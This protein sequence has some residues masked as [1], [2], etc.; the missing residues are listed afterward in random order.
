[1]AR[2]LITGGSTGI[3]KALVMRLL[4]H[5][6]QVVA[7]SRQPIS[8][9]KQA[10]LDWAT[11][12]LQEQSSIDAFIKSKLWDRSFDGIVNNAGFGL[13][14]PIESAYLQEI[15]EQ[16]EA[17]YFGTIQVTQKAM[18]HFREQGF[19][20]VMVNTSIGGRIAFPYFG[21]YNA[22]KHAL[23][24]TFESLWYEC[25]KSNI[26]IKIIEPGFTQTQF[27]THGMRR[28][29]ANALPLHSKQIE[30]LSETMKSGTT[31]SNPD[32]IAKVMETALFDQTDR[33]RYT[34]G[35]HANILLTLRRLLPEA[36]FRALITK[37]V[38]LRR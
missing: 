34:A 29:V 4:S 5:G 18:D 9:M 28:S 36:W 13:I 7:T 1:M 10:G 27:A 2:I 35:K 32:T 3:G 20:T 30:W 6:H 12:D 17:N 31:G 25:L 15:R 22:T 19:G 16:F 8:Q 21:Y 26:R 11:L 14:A 24:A 33:L 37:T 38:L 23:E